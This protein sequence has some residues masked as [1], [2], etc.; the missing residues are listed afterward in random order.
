[1]SYDALESSDYS[2]HP[3]E[4][5][6]F[7]LGN[8]LWLF[9]SAD[10][11]VAYGE[12]TYV[13]VYIKRTGFTKGGDAK[14]ANLDVEVKGSNSVALPFRDGWLSGIMTISIFRH[15]KDDV[16]FS[17]FWK[18]RVT[19]CRWTGAVATLQTESAS[20]MFTRPG[21]RRKYQV[22]CP[23]AHYGP[24]CGLNMDDW[25]VT[26]AVSAVEGKVLTLAGIGAYSSGYFLGGMLQ[27][28]DDLRMIVAHG[29]GV[30]TLVDSISDLAEEDDVYL[31][32]G[33][34]RTMNA[35]LNRFNN[36]DNYGGLPFLPT[37]NPFSGD[38][39]V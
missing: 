35:C 30:V 6:R 3:L 18:G 10:H 25:K 39:L 13:P 20:T 17:L 4:L 32:P 11:S 31:W 37:K 5:Y 38:A 16:D 8:K 12:D 27:R 14:K 9:T 36:L 29:A 34:P 22:G 2:G 24:A 19:S 26:A 23:H 1:M 33:C 28:G 7:A 15:H 21:L